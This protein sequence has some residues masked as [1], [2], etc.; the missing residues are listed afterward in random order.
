[1]TELWKT[2]FK[3]SIQLQP[4]KYEIQ[5]Q[6]LLDFNTVYTKNSVWARTPEKCYIH[7]TCLIAHVDAVVP[8]L[9]FKHFSDNATDAE[10][11]SDLS[12]TYVHN[13]I[14]LVL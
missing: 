3:H 2:N 8:S 13:S 14:I 1:L 6:A 4:S 10:Q 7:N 12:E 5:M 11:M 9:I